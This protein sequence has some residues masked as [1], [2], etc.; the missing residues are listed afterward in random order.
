MSKYTT[1]LRFIC[2]SLADEEESKGYNSIAQ[3]IESARVK[4]FDFTRK[5]GKVGLWSFT[6]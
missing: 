2:E 4:I 3:I 5:Q 6:R 1:E